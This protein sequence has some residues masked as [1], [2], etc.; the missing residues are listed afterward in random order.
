MHHK[1]TLR[2]TMRERLR[3]LDDATRA[4]AS[5]QIAT[6][7]LRSCV[8]QN[9]AQCILRSCVRQNAAQ[10]IALFG[11]LRSE[12]DLVAHLLPTLLAQ[13]ARACFFQ[14]EQHTLQPRQVRSM[15][16]L[17]RGA[18]NVWEPHA[19]CPHIDI[20]ALDIILVPGLAFT[21]EGARLG[22]GGG[23]YDRLLAQPACR[24]ERIAVAFDVQLVDHIAVESH[25]QHIHQIIT[26]SGLIQT[27]AS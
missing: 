23:Y 13:G 21:R 8:R 7:I 11:G 15:E 20:A 24:A 3:A 14:I 17:Q 25:D 18:M 26:E 22:R 19:H 27:S 2:Q 16:D 12:P 9:A 5:A 6:H 1:P 4:A 10:C